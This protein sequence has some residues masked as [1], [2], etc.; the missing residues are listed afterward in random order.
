[1]GV[2]VF[3]GEG[4]IDAVWVGV[5]VDVDVE[6]RVGEGVMVAVRVGVGVEVSVGE[7]V[8]V[9][10]LLG[11]GVGVF[12]GGTIYSTCNKGAAA[13]RP[14]YA[15]AVRVPVPPII[16]TMELPAVQPVRLTI[17]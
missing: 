14:S 12:S 3:V 1:M 6:V 9:G 17:S 2:S 16:I 5:E 4:V 15:S 10:V 8:N 11:V 13:G 7:G